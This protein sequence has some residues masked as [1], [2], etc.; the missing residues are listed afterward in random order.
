MFLVTH[1]LGSVGAP[2]FYGHLCAPHVQHVFI[3]TDDRG[4]TKLMTDTFVLRQ[5][6][7]VYGLLQSFDGLEF[8]L[9]LLSPTTS[10]FPS[11]FCYSYQSLW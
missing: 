10:C 11:K 8:S 1:T 9:P 3:I 2:K 5:L 4:F 6:P 7:V